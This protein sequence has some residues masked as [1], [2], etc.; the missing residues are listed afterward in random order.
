MYGIDISEHNGNINLEPY[1]GQFVI[2][3]AGYGLSHTD[4]KFTRNVTECI[5]LGIPFGVYWYSYALNVSQAKAEAEFLIKL[6]A[7]YKSKIDVGVWFDMEDADGYKRRHGLSINHDT[8]APICRAFA[9]KVEEAGYYSGI[10]TSESWLPYMSPECNRFDKWVA[11]WGV[12][13][14]K[15]NRNTSAYGSIIQYTSVPLDKDYMYVNISRYKRG[16][17]DDEPIEIQKPVSS[18]AKR[19]TDEQLAEKVIAGE[20]GNGEARKKALGARY[21]AV[22]ALVD[23]K[24]AAK[25][26]AVKTYYTVRSGDNLTAIAKKYGTTV[27]KLVSLNGIKNKNL[28]YVGQKL[29]VK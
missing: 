25:K 17:S 22:Q 12:N 1:K 13:N 9:L 10:Y 27:D 29:R 20:Y 2:I 6:L 5:R 4:K 19:L 18:V 11:S 28:I 24:L 26:K 23:K 15:V 21:E 3:R 14:G 8:I 7:P 16:K